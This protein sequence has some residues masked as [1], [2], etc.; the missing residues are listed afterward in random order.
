MDLLPTQPSRHDQH[1]PIR[2]L[3]SKHVQRNSNMEQN[4]QG[5]DVVVQE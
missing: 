5:W 3:L 2:F 1:G 4:P